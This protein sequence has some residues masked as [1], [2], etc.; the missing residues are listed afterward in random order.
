VQ[1]RLKPAAALVLGGTGAVGSAVLKA[2]FRAKVPAAFTWHDSKDRAEAHA[3]ELSMKPL[4]VD[5]SD[6]KATRAAV[7]GLLDEGF[8]P[9]VLV[10]CAGVNRA[11]ETD[12]D[13]RVTHAVNCHAPLIALRELA[14]VMA[15]QNEGHAV[16]VGAL[17]RGQSVP[18]PLAFAA[19]QGALG[20]LAMAAAKE[21]GPSGVRVNMV[22]LGLLESGLSQRVTPKLKEDYLK[23]SALRR[24]G[25]ADEAAKLIV[26]LAL[27]NTYVTGK[28]LAANGGL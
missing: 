2:L 18:M 22:A 5:L 7:R 3:H 27:E 25:T 12:E 23:L 15:K 1:P 20:S 10:H 24:L 6:P 19:S 4:R 14:P 17:D 9:N 8:T 28:V 21:L 11:G 26:W 13:W 16:F